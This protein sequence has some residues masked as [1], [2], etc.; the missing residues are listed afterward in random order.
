M[1]DRVMGRLPLFP[2]GFEAPDDGADDGD[3]GLSL[4]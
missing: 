4:I 1:L 2:A 3:A